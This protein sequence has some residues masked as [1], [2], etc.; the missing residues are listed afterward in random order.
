MC[1]DIY[2]SIAL[3]KVRG[4]NP[5]AR[6]LIQ[7]IVHNFPPRYYYQDLLKLIPEFCFLYGD[8]MIW[9]TLLHKFFCLF[10]CLGSGEGEERGSSHV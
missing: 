5:W 8:G 1:F 6:V 2:S 10:V 4:F 3:T 7:R 9:S